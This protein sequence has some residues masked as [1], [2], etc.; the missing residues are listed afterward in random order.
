MDMNTMYIPKSCLG[1]FAYY[2]GKED[3]SNITSPRLICS[4]QNVKLAH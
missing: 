4:E 2:S 1:L 3:I